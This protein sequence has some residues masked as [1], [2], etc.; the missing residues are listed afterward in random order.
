[1]TNRHDTILF[2]NFTEDK[3]IKNSAGDT[4]FGINLVS[5]IIRHL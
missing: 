5:L 2:F 3:V 4:M 1:M